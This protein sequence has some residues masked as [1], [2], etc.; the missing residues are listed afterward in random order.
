MSAVASMGY[1]QRGQAEDRERLADDLVS[2]PSPLGGAS[3]RMG[4]F[5]AG[6]DVHKSQH[7]GVVETERGRPADIGDGSRPDVEQEV[8]GGVRE[9]DDGLSGAHRADRLKDEFSEGEHGS[10]SVRGIWLWAPV[11]AENGGNAEAPG[12]R[13]A[14]AVIAADTDREPR[15]RDKMLA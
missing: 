3:G 9:S 14:V 2:S 1:L 11:I 15:G 6:C 7:L 12:E 4:Q 13:D 10:V 8:S 5:G